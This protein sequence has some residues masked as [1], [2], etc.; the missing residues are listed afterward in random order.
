MPHA[1]PPP[2]GLWFNKKNSTED[3]KCSCQNVVPSLARNGSMCYH[4]ASLSGLGGW[5]NAVQK[6]FPSA[7]IVALILPRVFLLEAF[8][9]LSV[10]FLVFRL[11][12]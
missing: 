5:G 3:Q 1:A 4:G 10:P 7:W 8:A 2:Q 6:Q 11:S 12:T 9:D